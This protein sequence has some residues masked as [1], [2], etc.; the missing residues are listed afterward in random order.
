MKI[1]FKLLI[2]FCIS[3]LFLSC[4]FIQK[5]PLP[6]FKWPL[7]TYRLTQKFRPLGKNPHLGIDLKAPT[8]TAVLSSHSGQVVYAG[9][10]FTGYGNVIIIEKNTHWASLY[11]HLQKIK[12]RMGQKVKPGLVI[13]TLGNTGRTSGP[14]LHFELMF[15]QKN[16]NPLLYLP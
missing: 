14:H 13:G 10:Q 8:G 16:V 3:F 12:V 5:K 7:K 2:I 4:A 11:A 15:K 9:K 6:V 1:Y